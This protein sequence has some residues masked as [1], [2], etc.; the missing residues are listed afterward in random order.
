[1]IHLPDS[2]IVQA[3]DSV[4]VG[5]SLLVRDVDYL[6]DYAD[7]TLYLADA[8]V[9]PAEVCIRY[10]AFPFALKRDYRLRKVTE[11]R[12]LR[13]PVVTVE[14]KRAERDRFYDIRAS[15]SKTVRLEAGTLNDLRVN[16]SLNLSIGGKIADEVEIRGVLSDKD[17]TIAQKTSTSKVK[18]LDRVFMEVR[19]PSAYARVG[20]LEVDQCPGELLRFR[21][22]M[23]GFLANG[24]HGSKTLMASGATTRSRYE[25]A[26]VS[27]KEGIAGP[28]IITRPDGQ[29]SEM[30]RGSEKVYLDGQL[31]KRGAGADYTIDYDLAEIYFN[32][33]HLIRD[34]AR[35]TVDYEC[36]DHDSRRQ[37]YFGSSGMDLGDRANIAVTFARETASQ[38]ALDRESPAFQTLSGES[39]FDGWADGGRFVGSGRGSYVRISR[40][41]LS[42]YEYV[43]EGSGDYDVTF[44]RVEDGE[45]SYIHVYSQ[46]WETYVYVYTGTGAYVDKVRNLPTPEARVL[47]LSASADVTEWFNLTSEVAQSKGRGQTETGG[48]D[49]EQDRAYSIMMSVSRDMLTVGNREPGKLDLSLKR[50]SIGKSYI[51]FDRLRAPDFLEKWAVRPPDG[52]EVSNEVDL[53]YRLGDAIVSTIEFGSLETSAGRSRRHLL[54][55]DLGSERFGL[56]AELGSGHLSSD[57]ADRGL[58]RNRIGVRIPLGVVGLGAGRE[59]ENRQRLTDSTSVRRERYYGEVKLAGAAGVLSLRVSH[60]EEDRDTG[61][62]W[63]RYSSAL[64]GRLDFEANRGRRFSLRGSAAQRRLDYAAATSLSDKRISSGDLHMDLRDV[65]VL[66]SVSVDYRLENT[67]TSM[68]GVDLVRGAT[69]GDFDSIGNYVPGAGD[70]VLSRRETGREPVTRVKAD[71]VVE[72]GRKGKVLLDKSLSSRTALEVEGESPA[73]DIERIAMLHPSYLLDD[74]RMVFSKVTLGEEVVFRRLSGMT[75][76]VNART[77]RLIDNRCLGRA[78]RISTD[79]VLARL[80]GSVFKSV[81]VGLE[82]KFTNSDS[83]IRMSSGSS[84]P[85][86]R[87]WAVRLNLQRRL[88]ARV[89]GRVG[90]ELLEESR[91]DPASSFAEAGIGPAITALIGPLRCD[92]GCNV[93]RILRS[94]WIHTVLLPRRNSFDWNSRINLRHGRYTSL[95]FEY[96]GRR[97]QGFSTVHNMRASLSATF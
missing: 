11:T 85:R 77:S 30:A 65:F 58:E 68:Y 20:D 55:L 10:T 19:S 37:F 32:P 73:A 49:Q 16:Q 26:E 79:E 48:A 64:E 44:T 36:L 2:L 80:Q 89:R 75:M 67:L 56:S 8:R 60:G 92:A 31:L 41:T 4:F 94:E 81:T 74:S 78:E 33:E 12:G 35:I 40:D 17:M 24:S 1:V 76:S 91:R 88:T 66:N 51:G 63:F 47:H 84:R 9:A 70:Y 34:G 86:R 5:D 43:G 50:R 96:T 93:K 3:S 27:G 7:G 83:W 13:R 52:F 71:L 29:R 53:G 90:L 45:G 22:N 28:Y 59:F 61:G 54:G 87:T 15:G 95:S 97:T 38:A 82:G 42:Y 39:G 62:G 18:D 14:E 25:S 72:V 6:L 23:T 57:S 69:G 21:R 46:D